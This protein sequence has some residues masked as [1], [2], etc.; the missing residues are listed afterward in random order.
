MKDLELM[1][2]DK[3]SASGVTGS[4]S[5]SLSD[6][7]DFKVSGYGKGRPAFV[8]VTAHDDTAA[9]DGVTVVFAVSTSENSDMSGAVDIPLALPPVNKDIL[10]A[11]KTVYAMLPM[12]VKRYVKLKITPSDTLTSLKWSS[13]ITLDAQTNFAEVV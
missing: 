9:A 2:F 10:K 7:L 1:F 6:T 5:A 12:D 8:F 11:G 13:G 3:K 4:T